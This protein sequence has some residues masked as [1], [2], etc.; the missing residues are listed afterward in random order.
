MK[1]YVQ[2]HSKSDFKY[3]KITNKGDVGNIL[4]TCLLAVLIL[5]Q[6]YPKSSFAF[7]A[8]PSIDPK[9]NKVEPLTKNQRFKTYTYVVSQKIGTETFEHIIYEHISG[10]LLLNR[11]AQQM[12]AKEAAM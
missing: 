2:Q 8:S 7:M 12:E 3:H 1:F 5:L 10:Y 11:K 9:T 6:K 4:M